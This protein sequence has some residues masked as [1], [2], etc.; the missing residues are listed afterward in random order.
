MPAAAR[1]AI[2]VGPPLSAGAAVAPAL[3]RGLRADAQLAC[4]HQDCI[5]EIGLR[6]LVDRLIDPAARGRL[7]LAE[8][9]RP[10]A[11]GAE[12]AVE[13]EDIDL[14]ALVGRFRRREPV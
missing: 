1:A 14:E 4:P 7:A 2:D 11:V 5:L 12:L 9:S 3:I 8:H 13:N 10:H 6:R